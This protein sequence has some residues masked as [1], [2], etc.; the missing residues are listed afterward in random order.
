M[1][2][3]VIDVRPLGERFGEAKTSTLLK[4]DQLEVIRLIMPAGRELLTHTAPGETTIHCLEGRV[5]LKLR[6]ETHEMEKGHLLHLPPNE[7]HSVRSLENASLLL[8]ILLPAKIR[9]ID[10]VQEASEESFPASD[11]PAWTGVTGP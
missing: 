7:P 5:E 2:G 10:E 3:R 6:E 11:S 1:L 4:T 9:Q 8:T